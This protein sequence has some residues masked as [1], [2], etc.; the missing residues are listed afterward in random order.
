MRVLSG[1][2]HPLLIR[3]ARGFVRLRWLTRGKYMRAALA[4]LLMLLALTALRTYEPRIV[5]E[6]K[7]RVFDA[8][9]RLKPRQP[10]EDLPV[11]VVDI[12]EASLAAFGQ[13]PWPRTRL[14]ALTKRLGELGAGVIAYDIIFSEPDRT[15]PERLAADLVGSDLPDRDRAV[16]LL[17]SLPDHDTSFAD[18]LRQTPTV[19]GFAATRRANDIRPSVK[20]GLAFV[21]ITPTKVLPPFDGAIANLPILE[22]AASGVGAINLSARDRGGVVRRL[23][24][25]MSDGARVYPGLAVEALR[26]AQGQKGVIIRGTGASG[27]DDTGHAALVDMRV[28]QFKL[29]LT[30]DGE[31]WL[32]YTRDDPG[33]YVSA[34]DVL[35]PAQTE[36]M[37]DRLEGTIVLVGTTASGLVDAR[38][39]AIGQVMPGVAIQ[40][41]MIEQIVSQDFLER[42]D[43]ARGFEIVMTLLLGSLVAALVL[44]AGARFSLVACGLVFVGAIG[45]SWIAFSQFRL[46][47][48][49]VYPSLATLLTYIAVERV[50]HTASDREKKFVRQAFGQY[51]APDL[52]AQ[53]ERAPDGLR[54][55]GEQRELSV[56]FMDVRGFTRL[57]ET[58]SATELVDFINTLLSPLSDAIQDELGTIDKYIG[59]SIMAFWNAPVDVPDHALRACRAALKMRSVVEQLNDADAFGFAAHGLVDP[60]VRIGVGLNTGVACVGN[61]GSEKRFNY[62]AMGDVV[63]VAARIESASKEFGTDLLVSEE[64][65]RAAPGLAL[66][67]AGE[68]MLKGK[69]RPTRLYALAG[70]ESYAASETF[71]E[72]QRSHRG[73]LEALEAGEAMRAQTMLATCRAAAPQALTGLYDRFAGRVTT[74]SGA[75]RPLLDRAGG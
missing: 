3:L 44:L 68:I 2:A 11:R 50:L 20:T 12:D 32:Y 49:P 40:A 66:L 60:V 69:S 27:D 71:T 46:L 64:V 8:Y 35:D 18:A 16:A 13:W 55:G 5:T 15:T 47:I 52:L 26:V 45:G 31:A 57:S 41:Q 22:E 48:D 53:L 51:L 37:R 23:P 9:Q 74:L 62:S 1:A 33:R 24:M 65:A 56:M 34:K 4:A 43:W 30:D 75:S 6:T 14:A 54:L 10:A 73:L 67:E 72:L 42:P 39:T 70:D 29:P 7:E 28:G 58:L 38:A 17:K 25:L 63:N 61:M 21:G 59:D 36:R 19:L